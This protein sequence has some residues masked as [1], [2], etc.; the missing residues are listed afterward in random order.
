MEVNGDSLQEEYIG[1]NVLP[2][3]NSPYS[4]YTIK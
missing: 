4:V 1:K 2:N 3:T